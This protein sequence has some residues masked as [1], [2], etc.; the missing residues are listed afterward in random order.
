MNKIKFFYDLV[1]TAKNK[2]DFKGNFNVEAM[3][4]GN[5]IFQIR[6]TFERESYKK[7]FK[8][9][10]EHKVMFGHKR[11]KHTSNTEAEGFPDFHIHENKLNKIASLFG[12]LKDMKIE[13]NAGQG[14]NLSLTSDDASDDV[15]KLI[16]DMV[17]NHNI[18]ENNKCM[19][20]NLNHHHVYDFVKQNKQFHS[21]IKEIHDSKDLKFDVE[22]FVDKK[23]EVQKIIS[24]LK[25]LESE[26]EVSFNIDLT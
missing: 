3:E 16:F 11:I 14:Y 10:S 15:K 25:S 21:F 7:K 1:S 2:H 4:N 8:S 20:E 18:G 23:Y 19:Q 9:N 12:I 13:E 26:K 6:N 5:K 24:K 22:V 17:N